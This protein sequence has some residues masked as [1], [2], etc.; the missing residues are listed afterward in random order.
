MQIC[1][2]L[3]ATCLSWVPSPDRTLEEARDELSKMSPSELS[4]LR[5]NYQAFQS[6]TPSEQDRIRQLKNSLADSGAEEQSLRRVMSKYALWLD[7]LTPADRESIQKA[8]TTEAKVQLVNQLI[9]SQNDRIEAELKPILERQPERP[10]RFS[11]FSRFERRLFLSSKSVRNVEKE[12]AGKLDPLEAKRLASFSRD[13]SLPRIALVMGLAKKY[14]I[15]LDKAGGRL[16]GGESDELTQDIVGMVQRA[17]GNRQPRPITQEERD[18]VDRFIL[19]LLLLPDVEPDKM[20][21]FLESMDEGRR[22]LLRLAQ[23]FDPQIYQF[24]LRVHYYQ[25]HPQELPG[26]MQGLFRRVPK[27]LQPTEG[28]FPD[29]PFRGPPPG[30]RRPD[31]RDFMKDRRRPPPEP[32]ASKPGSDS[33]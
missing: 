8:Q 20:V 26:R 13:P 16:P 14:R 17:F 29:G 32:D 22:D 6:L 31:G 1:L 27:S 30:S 9:K 11:A 2:L 21:G 4:R 24:V 28:L 3:I 33:E 5:E 23:R 10:S 18:E 25:S 7:T 15:D 12:L 19:D